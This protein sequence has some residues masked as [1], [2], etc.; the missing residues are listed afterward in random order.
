MVHLASH[1]VEL[2]NYYSVTAAIFRYYAVILHDASNRGSVSGRVSEGISSIVHSADGV[3]V[4]AIC[5]GGA[6]G[7][8]RGCGV[9]NLL[10]VVHRSRRCYHTAAS[11]HKQSPVV[12]LS[13]TLWRLLPAVDS[14]DSI[15]S[16]LQE[17]QLDTL[18]LVVAMRLVTLLFNSLQFLA[19]NTI[20]IGVIL[21]ES[22]PDVVKLRSQQYACQI[23]FTRNASVHVLE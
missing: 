6:S 12:V 3:P 16:D 9:E 11:A 21:T 4:A 13:V 2:L 15:A 10:L 8:S 17:L 1:C 18:W 5:Q 14:D 7:L 23:I 20:Y 22:L 19:T